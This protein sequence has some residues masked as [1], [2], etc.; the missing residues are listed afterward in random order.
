MNVKRKPPQFLRKYA[1]SEGTNPDPNPI[2]EER[3]KWDV[4]TP[5]SRFGW[6]PCLRCGKQL[7]RTNK[8]RLCYL[9]QRKWGLPTLRRRIMPLQEWHLSICQNKL[10]S[11]PAHLAGLVPVRPR[12]P[13]FRGR[14]STHKTE[15]LAPVRHT[16]LLDKTTS[17]QLTQRAVARSADLGFRFTKA[18]LIR[19][20]ICEHFRN[21]PDVEFF[22]DAS[23]DRIEP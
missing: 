9:C 7:Y 3:N 8:T 22:T 17:M 1:P 18:D 14:S 12:K 10:C 20:A 21:H 5:S 4:P 11:D 13:R 19:E 2:A 6:L 23:P 15:S 16:L